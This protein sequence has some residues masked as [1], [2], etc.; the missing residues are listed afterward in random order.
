MAVFVMAIPEGGKKGVASVG[1]GFSH[2]V[3]DRDEDG[4]RRAAQKQQE[5]AA[6]TDE[7]HSCNIIIFP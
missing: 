3:R 6:D 4:K 2:W 7:E 1:E 5:H